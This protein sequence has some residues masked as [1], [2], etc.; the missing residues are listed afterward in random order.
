MYKFFIIAMLIFPTSAFSKTIY[1]HYDAESA[2]I[3]RGDR[4]TTWEDAQ[5]LVT[6]SRKVA[7]NGSWSLRHEV[8]AE[9]DIQTGKVIAFPRLM[10][11][12]AL[13]EAYYSAWYYIDQG[14]DD[15]TWKN[16][17]Q[18][19]CDPVG[20]TVRS[21]PNCPSPGV[22]LAIGPLVTNGVRQLQ[23]T[24][25]DCR[26]SPGTYPQYEYDQGNA[27]KW[28]QLDNPVE[29]PEKKWFHLEVY[30]KAASNNGHII[31]WQ[32]G[33]KIFEISHPKLN[34]LTRYN[35]DPNYPEKWSD[36]SNV[37]WGI[38]AYVSE[39][40]VP[41]LNVLYTDDAMITDYPVHQNLF[42]DTQAPSAPTGF[43]VLL[44]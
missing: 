18:W 38:G 41:P 28:R 7:R 32:D 40:S 12:G 5:S 6:R 35:C 29:V 43:H 33:V 24:L 26:L 21:R 37:Y 13:V 1:F 17:M 44:Q 19:K 2:P 31:V 3:S 25:A 16:I 39:S 42:P 22:K 15:S 11:R 30:F 20:A 4:T 34:T 10:P 8:D 27:C 23:L 9:V 14:F 36:N